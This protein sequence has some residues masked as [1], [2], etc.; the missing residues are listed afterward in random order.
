MAQPVIEWD[1]RVL[2]RVERKIV[3]VLRCNTAE[4]QTASGSNV[5]TKIVIRE[6]YE[7][8][9]HRTLASDHHAQCQALAEML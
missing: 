5:S 7:M 9:F 8:G 2:K 1:R 4:F 6:F 3:S